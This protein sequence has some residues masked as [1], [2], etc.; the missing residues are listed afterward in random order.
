MGAYLR[1]FTDIVS[2]PGQMLPPLW[3]YWSSD[4]H[5]L[6][7]QR[8][9]LVSSEEILPNS[10]ISAGMVGP[11]RMHFLMSVHF[12]SAK[13]SLQFSFLLVLPGVP[14]DGFAAGC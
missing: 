1:P 12:M 11:L 3:L 9:A 8:R 2:S 13:P 10:G 4:L 14:G 6:Q 5:S 7:V